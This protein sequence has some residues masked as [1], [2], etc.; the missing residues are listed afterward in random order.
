ME[1]ILWLLVLCG[2]TVGM[3]LALGICR[4]MR[5]AE[6]PEQLVTWT[7]FYEEAE[8][9]AQLEALSVQ[10][11]WSDSALIQTV[12]LVDGTE[13]RLMSEL[14]TFCQTHSGFRCCRMSELVRIFESMEDT[15]KNNC[16]SSKKHV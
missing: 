5:L 6:L 10:L 3:L 9:H 1:G 8:L 16:I 7:A 15:E 14:E 11:T 2:L 12:W 13:G 4:R